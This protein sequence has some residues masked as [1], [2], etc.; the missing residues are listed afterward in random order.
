MSNWD[1]YIFH[2]VD[3]VEFL[4][5]LVDR[6]PA[7]LFQAIEDAITFALRHAQ[8]GDVEYLN[9]LCAASVAAIWCGAPFSSATVADEHPFVREYIG[10]CDE[11]LQEQASLLLDKEID[12]RGDSAPEGLETFAE[13][14]S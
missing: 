5:D 8:P 10:H 4:D 7:D 9:G 12:R 13:A 3:N 2:D 6:D 11:T 1:E 14:L